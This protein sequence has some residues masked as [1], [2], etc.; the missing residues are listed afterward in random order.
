M[1]MYIRLTRWSDPRQLHSLAVSFTRDTIAHL[2]GQHLVSP[3]AVKTCIE[4]RVCSGCAFHGV[5]LELLFVACWEAIKPIFYG[6]AKSPKTIANFTAC[7]VSGR[8][9]DKFPRYRPNQSYRETFWEYFEIPHVLSSVVTTCYKFSLGNLQ[10]APTHTDRE[11][12]I[13]YHFRSLTLK[14][15]KDQHL[16]L[17]PCR[18][19]PEGHNWNTSWQLR[20]ANTSIPASYW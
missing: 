13:L 2:R 11:L 12:W 20:W 17:I 19:A 9:Q 14:D 1:W 3:L 4:H 5:S 15:L 7:Y 16:I 10:S 8:A 6:T 18:Y